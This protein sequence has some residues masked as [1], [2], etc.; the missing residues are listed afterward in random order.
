MAFQPKEDTPWMALFRQHMDEM[1]NDIFTMR[2]QRGCHEFSPLM[3]IYESAGS[4]VIEI[5]LPGFAESD[6]TVTAI[7]SVL[8]IEGVKRPEKAEAAM[9]Y[10]CLERHYGRFSRL[11]DIPAAFDPDRVQSCFA[12][13][14][15]VLTVPQR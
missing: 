2:E 6:F 3:D 8:R 13:G 15:L 9:S 1:F 5:D 4:F 10:I 11:I 12:R 7:G 14:V